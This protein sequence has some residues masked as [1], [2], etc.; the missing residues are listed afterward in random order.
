MALRAFVAGVA[1]HQR[2]GAAVGGERLGLG[3][4]LR[5]GVGEERARARRLDGL[6]LGDVLLELL[7]ALLIVALE[8]GRAVGVG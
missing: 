3:G 5:G 7:R 4:F 8:G 1:L 6:V 2:L